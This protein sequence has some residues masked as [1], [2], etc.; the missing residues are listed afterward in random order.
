MKAVELGSTSLG[1][2]SNDYVVLAGL[3]QR[4]HDLAMYQDKIF[5]I[6]D[7]LGASITGLTADGSKHL[8]MI[9]LLVKYMRGECLNHHFTYGTK[10]QLYPMM[11]KIGE[12]KHVD[13]RV[14]NENTKIEQETVRGGS[15]GGRRGQVGSSSLRD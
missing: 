7:H 8:F 5:P 4:R 14:T 3:L 11:A 2:R 13:S 10:H 1:L 9:G 12:S 6:D 15:A